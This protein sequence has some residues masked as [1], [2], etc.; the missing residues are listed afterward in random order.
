MQDDISGTDFSRYEELKQRIRNREIDLLIMKDSSR[1]GRNQVESLLFLELIQENEVEL[2]FAAKKFDEDFFGLEAWFNERRA[3]DDSQKIKSNLHHK[4]KEGKLLIREHFGYKKVDKKLIIDEESSAIVKK[5][6]SLYLDGY[7]YR[8]IAN[9]LNEQNIPTPSQYM[10]HGKYP[11]APY[12]KP[13]H[14]QR[15]LV[16]QI[17]VGDIWNN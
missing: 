8:A 5:I 12:W 1:F 15:I 10:K 14:V 11:I 3:K 6:F 9:Q 4:M 2:E 13:L 7:G 17:Y 16:N